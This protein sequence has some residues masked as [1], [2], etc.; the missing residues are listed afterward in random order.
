MPKG[1]K[2]IQVDSTNQIA[3]LYNTTIVKSSGRNIVLNSGGWYT[4]H[5]K[6]CMNIFLRPFNASVFQKKGQWYV[7]YLNDDCTQVTVSFQD[8][9]QFRVGV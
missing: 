5:T 8:N 3:H 1:F 4:M 2:I 7:S 6:K 9:M